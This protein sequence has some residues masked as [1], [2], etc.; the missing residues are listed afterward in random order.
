MKIRLHN[1]AEPFSR[2][3]QNVY[4]KTKHVILTKNGMKIPNVEELT[5][6]IQGLVSRINP[7]SDSIS[8]AGIQIELDWADDRSEI[9]GGSIGYMHT[10]DINED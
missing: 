10:L 1:E 3:I 2:I 9:Y 6:V 5:D 4:E 8:S 7:N